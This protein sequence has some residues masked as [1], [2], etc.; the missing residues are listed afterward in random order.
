[1]PSP[2]RPFLRPRPR[3]A[4][5][6][7]VRVA[8]V[9]ALFALLGGLTMLTGSGPSEAAPADAAESELKLTCR[10]VRQTVKLGDDV[11]VEV[12]ISNPSADSHTLPLI[13]LADDSVTLDLSGNGPKARI[14][15][16]YGSFRLRKSKVEFV[17]TPTLKRRLEPGKTLRGRVRFAAVRPGELEIRPR[18]GLD[19]SQQ[20]KCDALQLKVQP[21]G[22]GAK[23]LSARIETA[24][25]TIRVQL[26]S[27]NAFNSVSHFWTL[28]RQGFYNGL[29]V[30]RAIEGT[31]V[32]SGDPRGDGLGDPGWY[33]PAEA[34]TAELDRGALVLA[35]GVHADSAGS[36]W[37][38][39]AGKN[40]K[41]F[42][43]GFTR[44]GTVDE[45][46]D[47]IDALAKVAV[48]PKSDRPL[49][50]DRITSIRI[51]SR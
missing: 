10:L 19:G 8:F 45:G 17:R 26:D 1:M 50:P 47:V 23:R 3:L 22:P 18:F 46:L 9:C 5:A 27:Q 43:R 12:E 15:R 49:E 44:L 41:A 4:V 51:G 31:L 14:M 30:H 28:A 32:Q 24:R 34:H 21:R 7:P 2:P 11:E 29:T 35:R 39:V 37:L 33:L 38:L 40:T 6:R 48:H 25:G 36:Q 20:L 13:R 42:S 16:L